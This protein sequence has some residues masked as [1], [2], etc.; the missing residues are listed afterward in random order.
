MIFYEAETLAEIAPRIMGAFHRI[1]RH[2][3]QGEPLT[4]RQY[5]ALLILK[6]NEQITLTAFCEQLG[7][8]PSTGT[9]LANRMIDSGLFLKCHNTPDRRQTC[10]KL[11]EKGNAVLQQRKADMIAMFEQLL[12]PLDEKDRKI[13]TE[14]FAAIWE[15]L[16][17]YY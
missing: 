9:E 16:Q 1:P 6:A 8:A 5:Q 7:L 14:S 12:K 10:L 4:M 11:S 15:I 17:K 2:H 13:L 3:P